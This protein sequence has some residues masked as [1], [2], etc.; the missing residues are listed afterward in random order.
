MGAFFTANAQT[1]ISFEEAE[2]FAAGSIGGQNGWNVTTSG[3]VDHENQVITD[4]E[5][6]QGTYSLKLT[7]FE[8]LGNLTQPGIGAFSPTFE[9]GIQSVSF[10]M[11]IE[12][13]DDPETGS[14]YHIITQEAGATN[15]TTRVVFSF[16]GTVAVLDLE[17]PTD[18]ESITYIDTEFDYTPNTWFTLT[19]N[20]DFEA[21]TI[22]YLIDDAVIFEGTVFAGD[23]IDQFVAVHDN[24]AGS[25]LYIDNLVLDTTAST[26]DVL[27]S[28]FSVYPNPANNVINIA[29]AENI[30]V[31]G[32]VISDLN[33][34][35][36]KNV[37]FDGVAEAQINVSDL[38]SGMYMMTVSSDKGTMTKKIVKN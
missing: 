34:R 12:A 10:D 31:N 36:V 16:D 30:L 24:W 15:L 6:S 17:D 26:N 38:A 33:G 9:T 11:F 21:G 3:E 37:S 1:T 29:N 4:E 35:T 18:P 2:G 20:Y 23:A 22:T 14:D 19:T 13:D 7:R 27:A 32:V 28:K 5:A 8:D 25:S